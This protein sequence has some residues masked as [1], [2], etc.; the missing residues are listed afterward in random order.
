[1]ALDAARMAFVTSA[2]QLKPFEEDRSNGSGTQEGPA[3]KRTREDSEWL[4]ELPSVE[5]SDFE[6]VSEPIVFV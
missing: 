6:L 2:E 3:E 1:M 5:I 4:G